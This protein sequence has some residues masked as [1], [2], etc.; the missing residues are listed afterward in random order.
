MTH[1][2]GAHERRPPTAV[3]IVHRCARLDQSLRT[4]EMVPCAGFH[5]VRAS[6]SISSIHII[7]SC[8]PVTQFIQ[9]SVLGR[10]VQIVSV[11]PLVIES[12]FALN[13]AR[14]SRNSGSTV[15]LY[16]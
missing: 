5:E 4:L 13:D 2:A 7:T 14:D 12:G 11:R 6:R 10:A 1:A 9:V 3:H 15:Y 16:R 8:D